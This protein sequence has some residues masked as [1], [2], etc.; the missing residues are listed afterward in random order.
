MKVVPV[1]KVNRRANDHFDIAVLI[2]RAHVADLK[3]HRRQGAFSGRV[4]VEERW[5]GDARVEFE[6]RSDLAVVF[7]HGLHR[8]P[9][10]LLVLNRPPTPTQSP[11]HRRWLDV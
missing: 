6:H 2:P 1:S 5:D 10:R 8:R 4:V 9:R 11:R 7:G 3:E